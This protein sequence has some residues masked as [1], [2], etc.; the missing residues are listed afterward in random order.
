MNETQVK[1]TFS[2]VDLKKVIQ[3][4]SPTEKK[5]IIDILIKNAKRPNNQQL[6]TL[7]RKNVTSNSKK[8]SPQTTSNVSRSDSSPTSTSSTGA[9]DNFTYSPQG[10][11]P[12]VIKPPVIRNKFEIPSAS[13][14]TIPKK[15]NILQKAWQ[16]LSD[17]SKQSNKKIAQQQ[18]QTVKPEPK[19]KKLEPIQ[20]T[21]KD[22]N[23]NR[24][25]S[26]SGNVIAAAKPTNTPKVSVAPKTKK[27][28]V[29]MAKYTPRGVVKTYKESI[30]KEQ[31]KALIKEV[32]KVVD[33][34]N[35]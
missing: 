10:N 3:N 35:I 15:S 33:E 19:L 31:L 13:T 6:L 12:P 9:G 20:M 24:P 29:P 32:K 26:A 4:L 34:Q 2:G 30:T 25:V 14:P 7:L 27:S 8:V 1:K 28:K 18:S 16:G 21:K 11:V 5:S 22:V 17:L 23:F